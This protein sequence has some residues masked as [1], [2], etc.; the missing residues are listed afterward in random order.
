[1][2]GPQRVFKVVFLGSSGVGKSSFIHHYCTGHFPN[3]MSATV[4][5]RIDNARLLFSFST[6]PATE[7]SVANS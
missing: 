3:K 4:G 1:Q 7:G 6:T 2:A 5:N